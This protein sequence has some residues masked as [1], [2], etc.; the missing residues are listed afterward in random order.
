MKQYKPQGYSS[1]SAYVV[2]DGAQGVIDFLG[3]TF[4]AKQTRRFDMPDGTIMHA[5][6]Q[7]DD[8]VTCPTWTPRTGA[9]SRRVASPSKSRV[10]GMVILTVARE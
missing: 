3:V 6:V 9:L 4:G 5:E 10:K 8:T 1:V 2:A 7:I